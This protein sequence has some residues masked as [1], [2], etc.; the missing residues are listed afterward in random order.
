MSN[1]NLTIEYLP[2]LTLK[3]WPRNPKEHDLPQLNK[4][5]A[6]FGYVNP[7][8]I[9]ESSGEILAGHG[10]L[11]A[12]LERKGKAEPCPDGC[13]Q[14][15]SDWLVPVIRGV[16]LPT[17]EAEAYAIADN[18]IVEIGGY[19][20]SLLA[21]VLKD[22]GDGAGTEGTGFNEKDIAELLARTGK[23]EVVE[24]PGAQ[25]DKAEELRE[26]WGVQRGQVWEVGRHRVMCGN[27]L[28]ESDVKILGKDYHLCFTS[29]PYNAGISS[30]LSGN[31]SINDNFYRDAYDDNKPQDEYIKLLNGFMKTTIPISKFVFVNIQILAGNKTAFIEFW[32]KHKDCFCDVAIWDKVNAAPQQAQRVMDSRFEFVL[33]FSQNE[34]TRAIGTK[35]FRGCVH[36]VY[37]GSPQRH[38]EY[39]SSH[40]ATYPADFPE[41]FVSNFTNI[42]EKVYDPFLGT[43]T[44]LVACEQTNRIGYGLEIEP[45]YVAVTLQ[46]LADMGLEPKLVENDH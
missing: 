10:R 6:R 43:G 36:N 1:R 23:G 46:R 15:G 8:I 20:E 41:Y 2:L 45:K 17:E 12:L 40:A 30:K 38:N 33:I 4:S 16:E 29:P 18:R 42:G 32:H 22:L 34:N 13:K 26:K 24:D 28:E 14:N 19:D 3:K 7:I 5:I 25:I 44:T 27:C 35:E 31:T 39:A 11:D 9:N 37:S 21:D